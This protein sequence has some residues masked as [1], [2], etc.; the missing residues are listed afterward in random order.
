MY[1]L[2]IIKWL[3]L[4]KIN[5]GLANLEVRFGFNSSWHSFIG[6]LTLNYEKF[7]S[8][9]YFSAIIF[10]FLLY[11]VTKYKKKYNYSDI[12]LY[13]IICYVFIFSYLHPFNYGVVLNHLGNPERDIVSMLLYFSTIYFFI[14]IFEKSNNRD[15]RENI[16]SIFLISFFVCVTTREATIPLI[17]LV[18]YFFYKEK[19]YKIINLLNIF[20]GVVAFLWILRSLI[21]S[22][23]NLHP[24]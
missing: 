19:K 20:I 8:K 13:L 9:Y 11:E 17:I 23:R 3:N 22:M 14:K 12:F 24:N 2:Q 6:L 10:S 5:F 4:H 15:D 16:I 7:S 1:H 21:H 18:L